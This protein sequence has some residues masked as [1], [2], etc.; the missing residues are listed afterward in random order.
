MTI[1][2]AICRTVCVGLVLGLT[3][4]MAQAQQ[5]FNLTIGYFAVR[6][7]DARVNDDVLVA[8]RSFLTFELD[9]ASGPTIGGEWLVPVGRF[10][11]AGAGVSFSRRAIPSLYTCCTH[12]DGSEIEQDLKIRQVPVAFTVRALPLGHDAPIQPYVGGG[13]AVISWRYS[14]SGEFVDFGAGDAIFRDSYTAT[15]TAVGPVVLGGVR[16]VGDAVS[17]GGEVRYQ[18]AEGKLSSDFL[19]STIDLGG[20]TYQATVGWRF[21]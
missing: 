9:D 19:G 4:P 16:F 13:L 1:T 12:A 3:A 14:E 6:G 10:L 20:W 17:V 21:R 7:E 11:E 2:R 5:T 15:G 18:R 8:N